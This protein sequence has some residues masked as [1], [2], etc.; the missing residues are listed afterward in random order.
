MRAPAGSEGPGEWWADEPVRDAFEDRH[1]Q[2]LTSLGIADT[3]TFVSYNKIFCNFP[4]CTFIRM[5]IDSFVPLICFIIIFVL[6]RC[7]I[8]TQHRNP[9]ETTKD[10]N[11]FFT[12][13]KITTITV[14][15]AQTMTRHN[16]VVPWCRGP[17]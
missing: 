7:N 12:G 4:D 10:L 14:L 3:E 8:R 17:L 16:R 13:C 6:L 2:G 15:R 9:Q 5:C 11:P 1:G